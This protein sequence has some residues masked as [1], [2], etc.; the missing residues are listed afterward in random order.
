MMKL[1]LMYHFPRL[2]S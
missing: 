1:S 2:L